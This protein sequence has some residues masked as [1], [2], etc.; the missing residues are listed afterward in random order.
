M[1]Q[2]PIDSSQETTGPSSTKTPTI[3]C[4]KCLKNKNFTVGTEDGYVHFFLYI[5][6]TKRYDYLRAWTCNE[7]RNTKIMGMDTHEADRNDVILAVVGKS[8]HVVYFNVWK[9]VYLKAAKIQEQIS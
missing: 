4:V 8:M 1:V 3:S 5:P 7:I 6:E 2:A 9:Q